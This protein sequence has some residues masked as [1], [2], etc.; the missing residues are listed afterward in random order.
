MKK[1]CPKC[2]ASNTK[3]KEIVTL[4]SFGNLFCWRCNK[5]T[6]RHSNQKGARWK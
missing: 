1:I 4:S 3:K 6:Y 2:G 5:Y